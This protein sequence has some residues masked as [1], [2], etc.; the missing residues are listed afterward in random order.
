MGV[1]ISSF[2]SGPTV[3]FPL[4]AVRRRGALPEQKK[5]ADDAGGG[6]G[7]GA[8]LRR[9]GGGEPTSVGRVAG[10]EGGECCGQGAGT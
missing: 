3:F 8:S 10:D 6:G 5:F 9:I 7:G 4:L 1:G 2:S